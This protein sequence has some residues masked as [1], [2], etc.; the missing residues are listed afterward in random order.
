ME[1]VMRDFYTFLFMLLEVETLNRSHSSRSV[2]LVHLSSLSFA[3]A[4]CLSYLKGKQS[5]KFVTKSHENRQISY[6][7][8]RN[9]HTS[10]SCQ[11][12]PEYWSM[13]PLNSTA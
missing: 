4:L 10:L 9:I 2:S 5:H 12:N 11:T 8:E 3:F 6:E 13:W 7:M 1:G